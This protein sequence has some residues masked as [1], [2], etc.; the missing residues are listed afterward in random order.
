M[1][2]DL[3]QA[4][5]ADATLV[6]WLEV[7][8]DTLAAAPT[9]TVAAVTPRPPAPDVGWPLAFRVP[10]VRNEEVGWVRVTQLHTLPRVELQQRIHRL[11]ATVLRQ[12]DSALA[13]TLD[14]KGLVASD[15]LRT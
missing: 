7:S 2:G 8:A 6:G 1:R 3:W 11:P 9:V 13:A 10:G 12:L 4:T 5:A 15:A 14:L